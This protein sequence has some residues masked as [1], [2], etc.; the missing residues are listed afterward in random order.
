MQLT[1]INRVSEITPEAFRAEYLKPQKP[2][3]ITGLSHSW[4]AYHK[5]TWEHF[6]SLVGN[7][8]VGVYNNI[9]AGA[10]VPVNGADDYML[11]GDYLDLIQEGPVELR[12]F[13][14]IFLKLPLA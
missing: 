3:I 6:K 4:P 11:F 2:V 12:I 7:Q 9:R 14:L 1:A 5:W 13:L 10:R 8:K